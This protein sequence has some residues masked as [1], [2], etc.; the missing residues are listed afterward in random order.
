M[1]IKIYYTFDS[2]PYSEKATKL[3]RQH[4]KGKM[5]T[6]VFVS[7][8]MIVALFCILST[9]VDPVGKSGFQAFLLL[10]T[11]VVVVIGCGI[12]AE[13]LRNQI[14]KKLVR[15]AAEEDIDLI[16]KTDPERAI[17]CRVDLFKK[18]M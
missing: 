5:R 15:K 4:N 11:P 9:L 18:Y 16:A 13:L 10:S 8:A 12:G 3:S 6:A 14:Y 2:F 1:A 17:Q 7:L